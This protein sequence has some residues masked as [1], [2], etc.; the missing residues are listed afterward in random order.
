MVS[1]LAPSLWSDSEIGGGC[2]TFSP[3]HLTLLSLGESAGQNLPIGAT[4]RFAA[5]TTGRQ[6]RFRPETKCAQ[7][8]YSGAV[9]DFMF[10][11]GNIA[12]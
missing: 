1:G 7:S 6:L 12:H 11:S 9:F 3:F 10:G 2:V 8:S 4:Q 5:A